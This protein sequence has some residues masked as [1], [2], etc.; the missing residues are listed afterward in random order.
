MDP[1]VADVGFH[2]RLK[3]QAFPAGEPT[4]K[5]TRE[6]AICIQGAVSPES[7]VVVQ[8]SEDLVSWRDAGAF[9]G[10]LLEFESPL[11]SGFVRLKVVAE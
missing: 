1:L 6:G 5:I 4:V 10:G 8:V 2:D 9:S 11:E 3:T 7:T